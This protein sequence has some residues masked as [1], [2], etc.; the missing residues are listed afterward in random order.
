LLNV[1]PLIIQV[2]RVKANDISFIG[3]TKMKT[4][5]K[6]GLVSPDSS[7]LCDC[8]NNLEMVTST[9]VSTR[10]H[11]SEAKHYSPFRGCLF[12]F[13]L[14]G[15][16]LV[17]LFSWILIWYSYGKI[18]EAIGFIIYFIA[19]GTTFPSCWILAQ[20]VKVSYGTSYLY[21]ILFSQMMN[22]GIIV[23]V[24]YLHSRFIYKHD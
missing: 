3:L 15:Y 22:I 21:F 20:F 14:A 24:N 5:R 4:C 2:S 1:I 8:G 13:V 18:Q 23:A 11:I 6:C 12:T 10:A 16:I 7:I 19:V 17:C 9:D